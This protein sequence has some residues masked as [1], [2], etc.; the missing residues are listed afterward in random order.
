MDTNHTTRETYSQR[1]RENYF[2]I[3]RLHAQR[4]NRE[5]RIL[6]V[7]FILGGVKYYID[8]AKL[9]TSGRFFSHF[10]QHRL[11]KN[12][13]CSHLFILMKKPPEPTFQLNVVWFV[14]KV[15]HRFRMLKVFVVSCA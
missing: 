14:L 10:I 7:K 2:F 6:C 11:N 12:N 13:T 5:V 9:K 4:K 1:E 3:Q 8:G 15:S